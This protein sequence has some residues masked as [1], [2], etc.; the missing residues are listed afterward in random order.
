MML[1]IAGPIAAAYLSGIKE[2]GK[3]IVVFLGIFLVCERSD[4]IIFY[5]VGIRLGPLLGVR[6]K[7]W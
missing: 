7:I 5:V 4:F 2:T 3:G 6:A 1:T